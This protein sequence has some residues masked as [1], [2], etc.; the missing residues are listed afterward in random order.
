MLWWES[1]VSPEAQ[2]YV[3]VPVT[4]IKRKDS[5]GNIIRILR[6]WHEPILNIEWAE[7]WTHL[8]ISQADAELIDKISWW[9]VMKIEAILSDYYK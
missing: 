3:K 6:W 7:E 2:R 4:I 1:Q 8:E 9:N 5:N